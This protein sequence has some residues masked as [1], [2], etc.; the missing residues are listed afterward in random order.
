MK[1]E[2]FY[3]QMKICNWK[4]VDNHVGTFSFSKHQENCK[5]ENPRLEDETAIQ[6]ITSTLP[7]I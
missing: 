2:D 4:V 7:C 5:T 6:A 1:K 3:F